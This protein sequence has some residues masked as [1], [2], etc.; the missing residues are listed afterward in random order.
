MKASMEIKEEL[1]NVPIEDLRHVVQ[2]DITLGEVTKE[3]LNPLV[4]CFVLKPVVSFNVGLS[5]F[6][7][8]LCPLW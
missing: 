8:V 6:L 1:K 2:E 3:V 5:H 7:S 4:R